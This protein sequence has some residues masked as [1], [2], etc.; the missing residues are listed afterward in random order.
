[1]FARLPE[2]GAE[3][4]VVAIDGADFEARAGDSV[5]AAL[6]ASGRL[7]SRATPVSGAPRGPFC[8]MG[9]CFDC[10]LTI[11]GVPRADRSA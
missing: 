7:A 1:M 4:V 5:A 10:L 2:T 6:L 8:L 9:V 3:A 11:D